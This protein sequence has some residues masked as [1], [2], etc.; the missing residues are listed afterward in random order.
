LRV[1]TRAR[2]AQVLQDNLANSY[3]LVTD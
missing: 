1:D 2:A 3:S